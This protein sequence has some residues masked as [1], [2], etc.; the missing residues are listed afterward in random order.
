MNAPF[1]F[2]EPSTD[3]GSAPLECTMD[4]LFQA[5]SRRATN[6]RA[7]LAMASSE[8]QNQITSALHCADA[9]LT[10]FALHFAASARARRTE[11]ALSRTM[12]SSTRIPAL[13]S[14]SAS[15]RASEPEPTMETEGTQAI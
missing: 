6:A 10:G 4:L 12:I 1:F 8:M 9:M 3:A 11:L 13:C 15:T 5:I 14:A 2:S 7:T